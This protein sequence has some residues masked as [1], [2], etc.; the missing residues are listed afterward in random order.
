MDSGRFHGGS[1]SS[2]SGTGADS[3]QNLAYPGAYPEFL[4]RLL[5]GNKSP[6]AGMRQNGSASV[7][8]AQKSGGT[9][10]PPLSAAKGS[11]D[12]LYNFLKKLRLG[13]ILLIGKVSN[14][15][16]TGHNTGEITKVIHNRNKVLVHSAGEQFLHTDG[17]ANGRIIV[18]AEN[19]PNFQVL[20]ILHR[21]RPLGFTSV[22]EK[23]PEKI[24]FADSTYVLSV[25]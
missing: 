7:E 10:V 3:K 22:C 8:S 24:T 13:G 25:P 20:H 12:M 5:F 1:G 16:L 14:D 9:T 21:K 17:D 6:S 15:I 2:V 23:P 18:P 11:M 19:V 4:L